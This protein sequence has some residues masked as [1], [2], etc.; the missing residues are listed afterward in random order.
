MALPGGQVLSVTP[1]GDRFLTPRNRSREFMIDYEIGG[2]ALNDTSNGLRYQTWKLQ[3]ED[4]NLYLSN[5]LVPRRP[6][7]APY[8]TVPGG[9]KEVALSFDQNMNTFIAWTKLDGTS[10]F[11]WWDN[12]AVAYTVVTLPAG[13]HS[14]R[15][16]L[17][18]KRSLAGAISDTIIT[19]CRLGS[20]YYRQL[21]DRFVNEYLI[22]TGLEWE[23]L[24]QFGMNRIL[25]LQWEI[26]TAL[27]GEPGWDYPEP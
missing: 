18:D 7:D 21:R 19:Y 23:R 11:R 15:A 10:E 1:Y 24:G 20:I 3:A 17:D 8:L 6:D 14:P 12:I 13:S 25:R 5:D 27:P 22:Y 2:S 4:E 9:V 16:S 26:V